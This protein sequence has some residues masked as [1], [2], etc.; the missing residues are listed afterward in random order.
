MLLYR[1]DTHYLSI[2]FYFTEHGARNRFHDRLSSP[3]GRMK[4]IRCRSCLFCYSPVIKLKTR[5]IVPNFVWGKLQ[6]FVALAIQDYTCNNT[7]VLM[8]NAQ[9]AGPPGMDFCLHHHIQPDYIAANENMISEWWI[10]R[11][12]KEAVVA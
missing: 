8:R 12:W 3:K 7:A 1:T 10:G 11:M 6:V 2:T 9:R 5:R 4:Y